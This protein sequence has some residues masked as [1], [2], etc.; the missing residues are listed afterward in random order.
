MTSLFPGDPRLG[1]TG[2]AGLV[3][4]D[5]LWLPVRLPGAGGRPLLPEGLA[6]AARMASGVHADLVTDATGLSWTVEVTAP[7]AARRAPAP[8]DVVVGEERIAR[9]V[10]GQKR[11]T[12]RVTG[13]GPG[14]KRIRI[15]LPQYGTTRLGRLTLEGATGAAA[16][17]GGPR[18]IAYGSSLT[19][20]TGA[21]GP[22]DT[23]PALVA[24]R[25]GWRLR[26]LG[27]ARECHLDPQVARFVR[28]SPAEVISICAGV[29]VHG[30]STFGRRTFGPALAGFVQTVREGH[31][32]VPLVLIS[33]MAAPEREG[34]VNAAGLTLADVRHIVHDTAAALRDAG[35][36]DLHL[37]DGLEVLGPRDA[38][39]LTDGLH[40]GPDG[41]RLMADRLAPRLSAFAGQPSTA[42]PL[43][44]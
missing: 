7:D 32:G 42:G 43:E 2:H 13:F 14:T 29:N 26:N 1:L 23:W 9:I 38:G 3:E 30:A 40:P 37:V 5:G 34:R 15:W 20:C 25:L 4:S 31:P 44:P 10:L 33:P 22:S 27:F 18:W 21:D 11:G 8:F 41:Y 16:A 24:A 19:H 28:D 12:L 6:A 36:D 35:E 39:L 17:P